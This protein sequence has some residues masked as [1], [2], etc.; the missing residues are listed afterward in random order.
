[1]LAKREGL[2][3]PARLLAAILTAVPLAGASGAGGPASLEGAAANRPLEP[4]ERLRAV[5]ERLAETTDLRLHESRKGEVLLLSDGRGRKLRAALQGMETVLKLLERSLGPARPS[6]EPLVTFLIYDREDWEAFLEALAEHLPGQAPLLRSYRETTGFTFYRPALTGVFHD[7]RVQEEARPEQAV[8][9]NL[10]HL[11]LYRRYGLLPLGLA[12]GIATALEE[13]TFGSVYGNWNREGFVAAASHS[14]WR[15]RASRLV[16]R[17]R[18]PLEELYAYSADP[19]DDRLAHAA[20]AFALYGLEKDRKGFQ[21]LL[22]LLA[23]E[24]DARQAGSG[25]VP[26]V[27]D[28]ERWV[29]EAFGPDFEQ[30]FRKW[31]RKPPRRAR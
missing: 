12:E 10:V 18:L 8:A 27:E 13:M 17:E 1:M 30:A 29:E 11:V 14:S 5:L 23:R 31:W 28:M 15:S 16:A 3:I 6:E 9:H 19:Y 4:G 21:A 24:Y 25:R 22:E 2:R 20:F 26:A 7:V